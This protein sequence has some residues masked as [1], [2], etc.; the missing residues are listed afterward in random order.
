MKYEWLVRRRSLSKPDTFCSELPLQ[1]GS[2]ML[3]CV[4]RIP[5]A[6]RVC[7]VSSLTIHAMSFWSYCIRHSI[8]VFSSHRFVSHWSRVPKVFCLRSLSLLIF[9]PRF[10]N[11]WTLCVLEYVLENIQR[12][13]PFPVR[14][15]VL[16]SFWS[17][18]YLNLYPLVF[19]PVTH[20]PLVCVLGDRCRVITTVRYFD[21]LSFFLAWPSLSADLIIVKRISRK[22]TAPDSRWVE[23]KRDD[24]IKEGLK[25]HEVNTN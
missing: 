10:W 8:S 4:L 9:I 6:S 17:S 16:L 25:D 2:S 11:L 14:S 12:L 20:H 1:G 5:E 13:H 22:T 21:P 19:V 18:F 15:S 23:A 7:T 24:R 3:V